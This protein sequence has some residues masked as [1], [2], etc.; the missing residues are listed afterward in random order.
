[1]KYDIKRNEINGGWYA[2]VNK[3]G[4]WYYADLAHTFDGYDEFMVFPSDKN[5][6]VSSWLEIFCR[7]HCEV[8]PESI[9]ELIDE[10]MED[11]EDE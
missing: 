7:R 5:G 11:G 6:N 3:D 2:T 1:M 9:E 4:R 10:F 8:S